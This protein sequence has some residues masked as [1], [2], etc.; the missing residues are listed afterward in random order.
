MKPTVT[1]IASHLSLG[2]V[3]AAIVWEA[4]TRQFEGIEGIHVTELDARLERSSTAVLSA[5]AQSGEALKFARYL[6]APER[7]AFFSR[8]LALNPS[9]V[10]PGAQSPNLFHTAAGEPPCG[11]DTPHLGL[12]RARMSVSQLFSMGAVFYAPR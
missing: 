4:L 6:A 12:R 2:A 8:T 7:A 5:S 9:P 3:D 10:I 11:G 1:E